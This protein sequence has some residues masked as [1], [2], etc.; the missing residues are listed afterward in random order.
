[1]MRG[2]IR[3]SKGLQTLEWVALALVVLALIG[4]VALALARPS[5]GVGEAVTEAIARMFR[6]LTDVSA[7]IRPASGATPVS[8]WGAVWECFVH[9][10]RCIGRWWTCIQQ[11]T[12]GP[13]DWIGLL[14]LLPWM[15]TP[16]GVLAVGIRAVPIPWWKRVGDF[17]NSLLDE[18]VGF[19]QTVRDILKVR[20]LQFIRRPGGKVSI[21]ALRP[22]GA[23]EAYRVGLRSDWG[24]VSRRGGLYK[25]QTIAKG[26]AKG[27][28]KS[29]VS[30]GSLIL[31]GVVS[32]VQNLWAFGT[33][34]SQGATF[35]DRTVKNRKFWISTGVDFALNVATGVAAA[36]IVGGA[37]IL[38]A[39]A[40]TVPLAAAV[41]LT[42][43]TS[44]VLSI[45]LDR[46]GVPDRIKSWLGGR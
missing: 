20:H 4:A 45:A 42:F 16:V 35:W 18:A 17:V 19:Y 7:C 26:T 27:L 44:V 9:P 33:D 22:R 10:E 14:G 34:P 25:P 3:G 31:S 43:V 36:A 29:R 37:L 1:M 13:A 12:C 46:L 15:L 23:R 5:S 24:F 28:L 32:L 21:R 30:K 41:G 2:W 38:V 40:V 11:G 6:C 8:I 39:P